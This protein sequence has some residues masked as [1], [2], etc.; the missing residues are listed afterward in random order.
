MGYSSKQDIDQFLK[1][2][3]DRP[4]FVCDMD[5]N[6]LTGYC[7]TEGQP[8]FEL[9]EGDDPKQQ[10]IPF[11]TSLS[12]I[13]KLADEG[14][15]TRVIFS[16]K[17]MDVRL[18]KPLVDML[19]ENIANEQPYRLTFLTSRGMDDS[20]RILQESGVNNLKKVSLVA[21]SGATIILNGERKDVRPLSYD[22]ARFL[23]NVDNIAAKMQSEIN[24]FV[25]EYAPD[26]VGD[27]PPLVVEHKAIA[28]NIHYR[29][30]LK[31][32]DKPEGSDIDHAIGECLKTR[33]QKYVTHITEEGED[34]SFMVLDGPMTVELKLEGINKGVGLTA[35]MDAALSAPAHQRP[36]SVVVA[37][38]D[39]AKGDGPG[40]DYFMMA[41]SRALGLQHGVPTFNIHTHH[42]VGNDMNGTVAD[43]NKSPEGLSGKFPK[44][45]IDLVVK[46]PAELGAIIV[47]ASK[48][49]SEQE[50]EAPA[51][52]FNHS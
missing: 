49:V 40:T 1:Q 34:P 8:A 35:L 29:E 45:P 3:G 26:Y 44:P 5:G 9:A 2:A 25:R 51:R 20:L 24:E 39:V 13:E 50:I 17:R 23:K 16:E 33:L 14:R 37:G 38:D 22:E 42:P 43:P 47:R 30:I 32:I 6:V 4:M 18:S 7:L 52:H 36:T 15:L 27:V 21:D 28:T 46:T 11:G 41:K 19:N 10:A 48:A 31:A 12:E